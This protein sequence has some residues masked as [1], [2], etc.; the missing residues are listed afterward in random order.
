[1]TENV[2]DL[3]ERRERETR[4]LREHDSEWKPD[5]PAS[6]ALVASTDDG[7][8]VLYGD[9]PDFSYASEGG[10]LSPGPNPPGV[11]VC[12]LK[13]AGVTYDTI[14][15]VEYDIEETWTRLRLATLDELKAFVA[16][17]YVFDPGIW[18]A[19]KKELR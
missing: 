3:H 5:A 4:L 16:G 7:S 17:D 15:G 19:V 2:F 11:W 6:L 10:D 1:M 13:A 18:R 14:D 8:F 12:E 9:G